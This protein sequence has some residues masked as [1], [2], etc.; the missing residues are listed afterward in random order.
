MKAIIIAEHSLCNLSPLTDR[1]PHPLLPLAGKP[2][3]MHALEILHRS[4]IWDVEV[5]SPA[6]HRELEAAIDTGP[7]IG[8]SVQFSPEMPEFRQLS[9]HCLVVGL[10]DMVDTDWGGVLD[11]LGD[12]KVHALIPIKMT[13]CAVPVALLLPSYSRESIPT[14]WSDIHHVDA[15]HLPIGPRRVIST[16]SFSA[17]HEANFQLLR[18]EFKHIK[19]AGR[20]YAPG[21]RS[22]PKARVSFNSV[23]SEYGYFGSYCRVDK[24]ARLSGDVIIG[25]RVAVGRGARVRDSIIFDNTY[26]GSNT[27]CTDSIVNGN[28]LIRVDTGVCL[29]LNDPVLFGAIA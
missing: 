15:I 8:M 19:A 5:V 1:T 18:G 22:A 16:G 9:Q 27:D 23:K 26:I 10:S 2:M 29:E 3:L 28:L 4:S 12:L 21:H 13:V 7:L 17:Y 11:E 20:E 14:D 25:D 6:L 24:S